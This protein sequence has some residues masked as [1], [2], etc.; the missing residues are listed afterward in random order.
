MK[1]EMIDSEEGPQDQKRNRRTEETVR[2]LIPSS[3]SI[4]YL[5]VFKFI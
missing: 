2:I 3:V 5:I 1:R 4:K